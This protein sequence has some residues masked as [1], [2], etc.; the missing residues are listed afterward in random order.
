MKFYWKLE[1]VNQKARK[2]IDIF[3]VNLKK[4]NYLFSPGN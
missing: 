3:R 2:A 1:V 4:Q